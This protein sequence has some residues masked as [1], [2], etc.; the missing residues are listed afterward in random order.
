M[1]H[2]GL[3]VPD[4]CG[5]AN[6][7]ARHGESYFITFIDDCTRYDHVY[8]FSLKSEVLDCFR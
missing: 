1:F 3:F 2:Y 4:I 5:L 8:V 6:V 7:R